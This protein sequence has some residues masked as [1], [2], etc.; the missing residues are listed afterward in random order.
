MLENVWEML[1]N[2]RECS[3]MLEKCSGVFEKSTE[4]IN[5]IK[6]KNQFTNIFFNKKR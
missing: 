5:I 3:G 4:N 2:V 1:E 6:V